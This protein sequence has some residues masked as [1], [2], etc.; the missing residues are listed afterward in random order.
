MGINPGPAMKVMLSQGLNISSQ[1]NESKEVNP[2]KQEI[3]LRERTLC[4]LDD[5]IRDLRYNSFPTLTIITCAVI[6]GLVNI[7]VCFICKE[8]YLILWL[9]LFVPGLVFVG[10]KIED[11]VNNIRIKKLNNKFQLEVKRLKVLENTKIS[12]NFKNLFS[13]KEK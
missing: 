2:L 4:E 5:K 13:A 10:S 7:V 11:L 6:G 12:H 1:M 3:K 8:P 9:P